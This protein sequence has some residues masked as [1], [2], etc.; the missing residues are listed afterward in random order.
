MNSTTLKLAKGNTMSTNIP[1]ELLYTK[2]HEWIRDNKDGTV[3]IGITD[4]AQEL[5]G[6][7]VY[8]ELPE[9]GSVFNPEDPVGVIESVKAASDFYSPLSGEVVAINE[10][11][12]EEPELIN[13]EPYGD[14]W[15]VTLK[16]ENMDDLKELLDANAYVNEIAES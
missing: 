5:L 9:D 2:S 7:V 14:G 10:K 16:L 3:T 4:H 12:D 8:V 13:S 1:E 11:L 15:V 6:D